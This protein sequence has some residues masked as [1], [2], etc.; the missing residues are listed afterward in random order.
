MIFRIGHLGDTLVALPSLWSVRSAFPDAEITL[1]SNSDVRNPNYI[2]ARSVLP[3]TGL[4]DRWESYPTNLSKF[5]APLYWIRL[6]LRLRKRKYEALLYLMPRSRSSIQIDR[7]QRFFRLA[8]IT[9][10]IG[11]EYLRE[12]GLGIRVPSPTPRIEREADF[13]L[14]LLASEG[15]SASPPKGMDLKLTSDEYRTAQ[16]WIQEH[17]FGSKRLVAIAPGSKWAS[18]IW[19]ETRFIEV[20]A[21][22]IKKFNV[23][24]VVLGGPEDRERGDRMIRSLGLGANAAGQLSVRESAALLEMC[25]LYL[26]NDTGTMHLAAAVGTPCVAIFAAID[27]VG[28]W[29]PFGLGHSI[30]RKSVE[31]E[32]CHSPVCFNNNK[33]LD[34]IKPQEVL[35][36]CEKILE[37]RPAVHTLV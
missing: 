8:G 13:L 17:A 37:G 12:H 9:N 11:A 6:L 4:V 15:I 26:G 21:H 16:K 20:V 2:S 33:C 34:L 36:A 31:C 14:N 23:G 24:P 3:E 18:K 28:K 10:I 29:E 19:P 7:D 5:A 30:L 27:W 32:G 22:L 1:L 25:D 35:E